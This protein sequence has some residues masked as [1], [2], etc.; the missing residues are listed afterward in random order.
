MNF[1][2]V[3]IALGTLPWQGL[4]R[5]CSGVIVAAGK[6][7]Q[8]RFQTGDA[9]VHWGGSHFATHV[10]CKMTSIVKM[11]DNLSF[12]EAAS[13]PIVF[14]TAY[15]SLIDSAQL[16][17]NETV[18]IHAAAGGVGQAAIMI[19]QWVGAGVCCTVGSPEKKDHIMR[20]YNIP[21]T[22]IF[23]SRSTTFADAL[24]IATHMKG[25]DVILNSLSGD[26]LRSSWECLAPFD[27]FIDIGKRDAFASASLDMAPFEK[28]VSY[29][30]I[31]PSLYI[32]R[33]ETEFCQ[34]VGRI[35][36]LVGAMAVRPVQPIQ[37]LSTA[38]LE[39][40]PAH[41]ASRQAHR[42][43]RHHQ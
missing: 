42:K 10:R 8:A 35:M 5:E 30:A 18:L 28:G 43:N 4:G 6:K 24:L 21:E 23:S 7:A 20:L 38:D 39:T 3:L 29:S 32:D 2:D 27:R 22:H 19:A 25:V 31:D 12:M 14:A 11:P 26:L 41:Y 13:I 9:V 17:K 34:L 40:G 36:D 15:A 33:R 1:K 16:R 37:C